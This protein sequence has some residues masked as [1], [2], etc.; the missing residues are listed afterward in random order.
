MDNKLYPIDILTFID[1]NKE[2]PEYL[3]K[4]L[5]HTT[6]LGFYNLKITADDYTIKAYHCG[7]KHLKEITIPK[8]ENIQDNIKGFFIGEGD[9]WIN[10]DFYF[11]DFLKMDI[12][13]PTWLGYKKIL[14]DYIVGNFLIYIPITYL[15]EFKL[16]NQKRLVYSD[17]FFSKLVAE[18]WLKIS[19]KTYA[20][21]ICHFSNVIGRIRKGVNIPN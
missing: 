12:T 3:N 4:S 15:P 13:K 6:S 2:L 19:N 21:E 16:D 8:I 17:R 11:T 5:E 1:K 18:G 7:F 10:N 20:D 9:L 14:K